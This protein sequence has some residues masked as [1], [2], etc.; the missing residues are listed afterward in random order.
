MLS[1][2]LGVALLLALVPGLSRAQ[3]N[4]VAPGPENPL[5]GVFG[6]IVDVRVVNI[7][8]V[9]TDK[10]GVPVGGLSPDDFELVVDG[11][12]VDIEYFSEVVGGVAAGGREGA[13]LRASVPSIIPGN[14]V[15]TSYLV[16]I[17]EFFSRPHDRDRVIDSVI[18]QLAILGREDRM[19]IVAYDGEDLEMLTSWSQSKPALTKILTDAK[20]RKTYG[21]QR[22]FERRQVRLDLI[23]SFASGNLTGEDGRSRLS[24]LGGLTPFERSYVRRLS[25]QVSET[26]FAAAATLRSFSNPPGR[27]V[28]MLLS[29]GWPY[30]PA[31]TLVDDRVAAGELEFASV[32]SIYLDNDSLGGPALFRPLVDEA[33]LLGYTLYPVDIPGFSPEVN[34]ALDVA[35]NVTSGQFSDR[36]FQRESDQHSS[37]YFLAEETGGLPLINSN[38][39]GALGE[40]AKDVSTYYWLGFNPERQWDDARHEID[41]RLKSKGLKLRSRSGFLDSSRTREAS[42]SVESALLFGNAPSDKEVPVRVGSSERSGRRFMEVPITVFVPLDDITMIPIGEEWAAELEIRFAVKDEEGRR[43]EIPVIPIQLR[44]DEEPKAK[45]L[46]RYDTTLRLRRLRHDAVVS[47]YDPAG[48]TMLAT[49]IQILP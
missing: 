40:V 42:M 11:E 33:N 31:S 48:G 39:I 22:L 24:D 4:A 10:Q 47:L 13:P 29:G 14:A 28:M 37:L 43:A 15:G 7:E 27:K 16:F 20:E 6:E 9:V 49:R 12:P 5:P 44:L 38:R 34:S 21:M 25:G 17:D 18:E 26:I 36:G 3:K 45:G 23:S 30:L 41:V 35:G 8:V 1:T 19:A 2:A 46:A 32:Q